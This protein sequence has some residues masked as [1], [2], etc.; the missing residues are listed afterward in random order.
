LASRAA[1]DPAQVATRAYGDRLAERLHT[2]VRGLLDWA[3]PLLAR[4]KPL[5]EGQRWLLWPE[6]LPCPQVPPEVQVIPFAR[7]C[8]AALT[9]IQG[10]EAGIRAEA[11][12]K[13]QEHSA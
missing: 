1:I 9:V 8:T 4:P 6:G 13:S 3:Q 7:S 10:L 12:R 5:P 2:A 11:E